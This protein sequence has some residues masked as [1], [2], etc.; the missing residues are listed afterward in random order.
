MGSLTGSRRILE[1]IAHTAM[2]NRGLLPDFSLQAQQEVQALHAAAQPDASV[3]DLRSLLWCSIDNDDSRDLD[4]LSVAEPIASGKVR[5]LVAVAD[6]DALVSQSSALDQHASHNT[7]SVYT[8][9]CIFPMLPVR[10]STD[11]TSLGQDVER[12]ALIVDMTIDAHGQ[13]CESDLYRGRVVNRAKLAYDGVSD[14]LC[15]GQAPSAL[16]AVPGMAEQLKLQDQV[17]AALRGLRHAHGALTLETIQTHAVFDGEALDDLVPDHKGRANELIEDFMIA[18]NGATALF[19]QQRG[20]PSI[21]RVLRTPKRWDR[22]VQMASELGDSLPQLPDAAAL[23]E[24]LMRRRQ[25]APDQFADLS[26]AVIKSLGA[27]E[28]VADLPG[29]QVAG[30]FGLA[31][32]DYTHSTAPNRRFADLISQR[33][34][35]AALAGQP[36]PYSADQLQAL[37][38]H[39]TQQQDNAAKVERRVSKSAAALLLSDRVGESFTALVTG[40][41]ATGTWVRIAAPCV[42]GRLIKGYEGADVGQRLLVRLVQA[43]VERGFID[44]AA[45][46]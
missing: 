46:R 33:L 32:N 4:Q 14:W 6:V 10:L 35:K 24:F 21:R 16:A 36:P 29:Q 1:R 8:A 31:V 23:N 26:L 22:L 38:A 11:L 18:A 27:G 42:E 39:C 20:F 5:V 45:Q 40:V 28:Y 12:L 37:A 34:V 43:D 3:R 25:L 41:S 19:L 15:G 2:L 13:V 7:T 44:F 9:A 30:H 17:A